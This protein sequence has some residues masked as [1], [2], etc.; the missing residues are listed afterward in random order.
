MQPY[1]QWLVAL[2]VTTSVA[3]AGGVVFLI[4]ESKAAG[5][6]EEKLDRALEKLQRIDDR[7]E[8]VPIHAVKIGQ[9]E[10]MFVTLRSDIRHLLRGSGRWNEDDR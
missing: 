7:L 10:E 3:M 6:R 8:L 1:T 2:L 5:R 4:R 9:L